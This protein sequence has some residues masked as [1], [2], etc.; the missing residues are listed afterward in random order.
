MQSQASAPNSMFQYY[1]NPFLNGLAYSPF[2]NPFQSLMANA[3]ASA[4]MP[5]AQLNQNVRNY[6]VNCYYKN[7]CVFLLLKPNITRHV[8]FD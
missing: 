6:N 8:V 5:N 3:F 1:G 7:F 2:S 4:V